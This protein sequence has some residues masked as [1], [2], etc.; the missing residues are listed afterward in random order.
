MLIRTMMPLAAVLLAAACEVPLAVSD[1]DFAVVSVTVA[2]KSVTLSVG[3]SMLLSAT[4]LMS[5]NRPPRAVSWT[6]SNVTY[7]TV[8]KS[9]MVYGV[10]AGDVWIYATSTS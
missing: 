2:P 6:S 9:G 7:A 5:N 8:N 3:D 10:G 4:V 1:P